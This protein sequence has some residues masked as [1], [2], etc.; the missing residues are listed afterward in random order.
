MRFLG[1]AP[2]DIADLVTKS[3]A[4]S[5]GGGGGGTAGGMVAPVQ[6]H[7]D[8]TESFTISGGN[9]TQIAGTVIQ[10]RSMGV[11]DRLLV[12]S[13]P[14]S[15]GVGAGYSRTSQPANG[16]YVVTAVG[17]DMSVS[18]ASD[19]SGSVLPHGLMVYSENP[20][21]GWLVNGVFAVYTPAFPNI[22]FTYGTDAIQFH[23]V[24]GKSI[25]PDTLYVSSGVIGLWNNTPSVSTYLK[26]NPAAPSGADQQL[27][28][29]AVTTGTLMSRSVV[30]VNSPTTLAVAAGHEYTYLLG[31]GA[32]PTVPT[33]VNNKTFYRLKNITN[34]NIALLTTSN[35][36][37]DGSTTFL[38]RPYEARDLVNDNA[39]WFIF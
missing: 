26:V 37:I 28:L 39:N 24:A 1:P 15:S 27:T 13:A 7:C 32:V 29:P 10:Y 16:I 17:S 19:F 33:A 38:L 5:V 22:S 25:N 18:R 35:Q 30:T 36:T 9:I 34:S 21:G 8:G 14:A 20:A 11:G 23:A 2:T 4:D 12:M 31:V 3:Y 6:A